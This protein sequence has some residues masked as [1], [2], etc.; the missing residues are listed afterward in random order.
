[1]TTEKLENTIIYILGRAQTRGKKNLSKFEL[2]KYLY[3]LETEAYRF[4]GKSFLDNNVSFVRDKNGPISI[5]IYNAITNLEGDYIQLTKTKQKS[6]PYPRHSISLKKNKNKRKSSLKNSEKL[7]INS[8]LESYLEL[9]QKTLKDIVYKTE[10]MKSI[11][12]EEKKKKSS[13]KG[14]RLNLNL[15]ALDEDMVDLISA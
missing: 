13:L 9:P 4:T 7:F 12:K 5:D 14:T 8:V 10:P 6:Y 1:M 11:L 15:I 2:F 3:L